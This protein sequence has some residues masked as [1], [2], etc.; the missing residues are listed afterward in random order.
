MKILHI[1]P[2]LTPWSKA[3]GLGDA[4]AGLVKALAAEGHEVRVVSPLYGS[5]PDQEKLTTLIDSLKVNV[6][7]DRL[8]ATCRVNDLLRARVVGSAVR[9]WLCRYRSRDRAG[10]RS[11]SRSTR[12]SS[13]ASTVTARSE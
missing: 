7:A 8:R 3:G 10:W 5:V 11:R 1:T 13:T 2:E 4:V 6:A 9:A 12:A